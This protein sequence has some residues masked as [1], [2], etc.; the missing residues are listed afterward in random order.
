MKVLKSGIEID[1]S[2][3]SKVKG[4]ACA[5]YCKVGENGD[6]Q[7]GTGHDGN[8]C[9]CNCQI[10]DQAVPVDGRVAEVYIY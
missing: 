6:Y 9:S 8:G 7:H 3:L 5:C 2:D 4:S 10:W 1:P